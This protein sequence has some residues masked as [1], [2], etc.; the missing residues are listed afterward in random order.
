VIG[1]VGILDELDLIGVPHIGGPHEAKNTIE[2]KPGFA[3]PHDHDVG[4]ACM[5]PLRL[6]TYACYRAYSCTVVCGTLDYSEC[7]VRY[8][9]VCCMITMLEV[10]VVCSY[11][12]AGTAFLYVKTYIYVYMR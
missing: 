10:R 7:G 11:M 1:E 6:C 12:H 5:Q 3:L 9:V 2:L 4:G 8:A